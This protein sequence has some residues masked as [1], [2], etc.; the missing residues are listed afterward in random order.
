MSAPFSAPGLPAGHRRVDEARR[1]GPAAAAA[2]SRATAAEAVVWS[3]K[4]APA[5][6]PSKAPSGPIV[7]LRRSSS[8]PT[9]AKTISA[10][11]AASAGVAA[12]ALPCCATQASARLAVRL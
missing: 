7:T 11:S 10:P 5:P 9:Q 4:T 8:L 3:T 6:R 12:L 2:S 1:R